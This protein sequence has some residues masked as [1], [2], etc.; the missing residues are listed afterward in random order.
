M[1]CVRVES[2]LTP[3]LQSSLVLG[4]E[5]GDYAYNCLNMYIK[6]PLS[7]VKDKLPYPRKINLC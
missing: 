6:E 5:Q 2:L 1:Q 4:L 7:P 3:L